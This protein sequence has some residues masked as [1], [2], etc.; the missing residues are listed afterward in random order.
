MRGFG[1][2]DAGFSRFHAVQEIASV[3]FRVVDIVCIYAKIARGPA[4]VGRGQSASCDVYPAVFAD[5]L[6]AELVLAA[7]RCL[8]SASVLATNFVLMR[9]V[10]NIGVGKG[11]ADGFDFRRAGPVGSES[12]VSD[13]VVVADPVHEYSAA[14]RTVPSPPAMVSGSHVR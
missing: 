13:V 11:P 10:V 1:G 9:S 6:C 4:F 3:V 12:P 5:E 7:D 2:S 14:E 8:N